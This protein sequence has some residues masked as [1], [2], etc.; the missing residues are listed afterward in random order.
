M[1]L[2]MTAPPVSD[3]ALVTDFKAAMR[4][5]AA[6]VTLV[7]TCADGHPHGMTATA[8][9]SLSADPPSVLVCINRTASMH[10]PTERS[11]HFCLNLLAAEQAELCD[12][13]GARRGLERFDVGEWRRGPHGL[14]WL[15]GAAATIFCAVDEALSYGT[16]TIFIGRIEQ[17]EVAGAAEPLVYQG[18][19]F[20]RFSPA[21][22]S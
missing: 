10:G 4:Q 20:G 16:H 21:Q 7:T 1:T 14:P 12:A 2:A 19:A 6:T 17:V 11:R 15:V 13:F 3:P 5:L 22:Q 8:V 9:S 18:G